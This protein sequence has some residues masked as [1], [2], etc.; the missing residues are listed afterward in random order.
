MYFNQNI[1]NEELGSKVKAAH[2][3]HLAFIESMRP[4]WELEGQKFKIIREDLKISRKELSSYIGIS[5]QVI[6]KFE[7]GK[8][9]RSRNMLK[10]SYQTSLQLIQFKRNNFV[11]SIK[12]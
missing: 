11:D 4:S 7:K 9:V 2:L 6:A 3:R 10:T 12:K 8:S 5:D 1:S